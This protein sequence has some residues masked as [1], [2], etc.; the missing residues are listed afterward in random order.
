MIPYTDD[1]KN[2]FFIIDEIDGGVSI[3]SQSGLYIGRTQNSN[4]MNTGITPF[5]NTIAFN[6]GNAIITSSA[7]PT[8]QKNSGGN[9]FR[10]FKSAQKPI[11]LYKKVDEQGEDVYTW[12]TLVS[13]DDID[14]ITEEELDDMLVPQC[15]EGN[16]M[17][18]EN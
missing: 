7:G 16:K 18:C 12:K 3:Q 2:S 9:R 14:V 10:Y 17:D 11:Q 15:I 1:N 4:G 6:G 13:N 5:V 8:L